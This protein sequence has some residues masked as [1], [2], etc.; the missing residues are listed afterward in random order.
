VNAVMNFGFHKGREFLDQLSE[1]ELF[2][3]DHNTQLGHEEL[4]NIS[5][6]WTK[7]VA[8]MCPFF[9]SFCD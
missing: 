7:Q 1:Y 2:K 6:S 5:T 8:E 3:K 4:C 9:I